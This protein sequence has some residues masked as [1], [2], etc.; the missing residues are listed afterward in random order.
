MNTPQLDETA[1]YLPNAPAS[2]GPFFKTKFEVER[3]GIRAE[4]IQMSK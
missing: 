2:E 3:Q 4:S 1:T